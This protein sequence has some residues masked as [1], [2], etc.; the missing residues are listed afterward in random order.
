MGA[1]ILLLEDNEHILKINREALSTRGYLTLEAETISKGNALLKQ[2]SPDL[3]ICDIMLPDGDGVA[4]YEALRSIRNVPCLFL[5]SKTRNDIPWADMD[6]RYV[7]YLA[8]PYRLNTLLEKVEALLSRASDIADNGEQCQKLFS[9]HARAEQTQQ[10]SVA[11]LSDIGK[12]AQAR[13]KSLRRILNW[14]GAVAAALVIITVAVFAQSMLPLSE[15]QDIYYVEINDLG[16][17]FAASPFCVC[18]ME[19][20]NND[21]A[22]LVLK[23][24]ENMQVFATALRGECGSY[25]F[26]GVAD[27]EYMVFALLTEGTDTKSVKIGRAVVINGSTDLLLDRDHEAFWQ[28]HIEI[29]P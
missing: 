1:T 16:V 19:Q 25:V 3:L 29:R 4:F 15:S 6:T 22:A 2:H 26:S 28:G 13:R 14:S 18:V 23:H 27:G 9:K 11:V 10:P 8:K 20:A 17:P 24:T 12:S 5:S 7:D 21:Y